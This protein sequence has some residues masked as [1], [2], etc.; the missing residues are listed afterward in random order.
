MKI[1]N[2]LS[3]NLIPEGG[4]INLIPI[5]A[6]TA[7]FL[8]RSSGAE[9]YIGH[10][11]TA[12]VISSQLGIDVPFNRAHG[13]IEDAAIIAQYVG[14]RLPEGATAL[15]DGAE[16]RFFLAKYAARALGGNDPLTCSKCGHV[17]PETQNAFWCE[18]C[19][20]ALPM[21]A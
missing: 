18:A 10:A 7:A 12:A 20:V 9:S 16:I 14:P 3:I 17:T 4:Q 13:S 11:E 21:P 19:G 6:Q 15:P 1:F 8:L 2:A 5:S